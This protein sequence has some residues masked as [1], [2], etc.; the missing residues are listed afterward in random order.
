MCRYVLVPFLPRNY[1]CHTY[2]QL[3]SCYEADSCALEDV[4]ASL[5]I[6]LIAS[7][8]VLCLGSGEARVQSFL[9]C[10]VLHLALHPVLLVGGRL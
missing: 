5:F 9:F 4:A 3:Y 6:S 10:H 8:K 1:V 7:D 2:N